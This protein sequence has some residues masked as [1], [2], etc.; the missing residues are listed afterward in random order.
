MTRAFLVLALAL[1]L[2]AFAQSSAPQGSLMGVVLD[3]ATQRPL[4]GA[5]VTARGAQLVGEQSATTDANG[6]FEITMLPTGIYSLTVS[7]DGYKTFEPGGLDIRGK[8]V[9]VKLSIEEEEAPARRGSS[10]ASQPEVP[11]APEFDAATM[12]PPV[13][14][15]GPAP[16]YTSQAVEQEVEG[17]MVVRC[18]VLTDGSVRG[19]LVKQGLPF[20]NRAVV[21]AL[22]ARHYKPATQHGKP[23]DVSYTFTIRLKLPAADRDMRR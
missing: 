11:A 12:T 20:M 17:T 10:R 21:D 6:F 23:I 8:R 14:L 19:C 5:T 9:R 1:P 2:T 22:E 18:V 7:H 4:E 3:A 13:M 16:E 15:S